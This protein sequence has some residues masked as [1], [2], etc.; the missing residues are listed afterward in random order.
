MAEHI[1]FDGRVQLGAALLDRL[2]PSCLQFIDLM[3]GPFDSRLLGMVRCFGTPKWV[4]RAY[5]CRVRR[6]RWVRSSS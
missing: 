2:S 1:G 5:I 4:L 6:R 3:D